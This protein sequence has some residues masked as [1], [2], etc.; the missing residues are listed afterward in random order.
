MA[1][2][3][4]KQFESLIGKYIEAV[5]EGK[6]PKKVQE[7]TQEITEVVEKEVSKSTNNKQNVNVVPYLE[8]LLKDV[9]AKEIAK[10]KKDA[11]AREVAKAEETIAK[12]EAA[13]KK[14]EILKKEVKSFEIPKFER[15]E[16]K[17]ISETGIFKEEDE[18]LSHIK[19]QAEAPTDDDGLFINTSDLTKEDSYEEV[20]EKLIEETLE[21]DGLDSNEETSTNNTYS[22]SDL[23]SNKAV[24]VEEKMK[25]EE[26]I[27]ETLDFNKHQPTSS[28]DVEQTH[29]QLMEE[30]TSIFD[31]VPSK[32]DTSEISETIEINN[33][34]TVAVEDIVID[35]G[36]STRKP[37]NSISDTELREKVIPSMLER[38]IEKSF[39][40]ESTEYDPI[41]SYTHEKKLS[42]KEIKKLKKEKKKV[43]YTDEIESY[44]EKKGKDKKNNYNFSE[45]SLETADNELKVDVST[46]EVTKPSK[47]KQ[48][49]VK[50]SQE[51]MPPKPTLNPFAYLASL[52]LNILTL[53]SYGVYKRRKRN[54]NYRLALLKSMREIKRLANTELPDELST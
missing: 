19:P 8:S 10:E 1:E 54:Y 14:E 48:E 24:R 45:V 25:F 26:S 43:E 28:N 7:A 16:S 44:R 49:F 18:I 22:S 5:R 13:A 9:K 21:I 3:K 36:Y 30:L 33:T 4:E 15:K 41:A 39:D 52:I 51:L 46:L 12:Q 53:M 47:L 23:L 27:S 37:T 17:D 35:K 34:A 29:E 2:K 6:D 42:K 11:I 20:S 31:Q 50:T 32:E 40:K 38:G